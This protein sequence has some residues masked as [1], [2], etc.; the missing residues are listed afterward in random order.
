MDLRFC[1]ERITPQ[2][3][4]RAID[5]TIPQF[6]WPEECP[7]G[8]SAPLP[9][10]AEL[11]MKLPAEMSDQQCSVIQALIHRTHGCAPFLLLLSGKK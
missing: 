9:L 7:P 1:V 6:V 3:M 2:L 11:A 8:D 4:H 5:E 10:N